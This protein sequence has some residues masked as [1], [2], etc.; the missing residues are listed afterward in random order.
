MLYLVFVTGTAAY[1]RDEITLW[2]KPEAVATGAPDDFVARGIEA[3]QARAPEAKRWGVQFPTDRSPAFHVQWQPRETGRSS[4]QLHWDERT[5]SFVPV[6]GTEGGN[7]LYRFHYSLEMEEAGEWI[8]GFATL[9]LCIAIL[10]GVVTHRRFF[11][12]FFTFRPGKSLSRSWLD[13]HN[14]TGV[15][16]LP[17]HIMISYTGLVTLMFLYVPWAQFALYG[18][19][20]TRFS[21]EAYGNAKAP[22]ALQRPAPLAD[23]AP[24]IRAVDAR[25]GEGR[26][27]RLIVYNPGDAGAEVEFR[28]NYSGQ[29]SLNHAKI[30]FSGTDGTLVRDVRGFGPGVKTRGG[31]VGMHIARFAEPV[32]RAL[33]FLCGLVGSVMIASGL[34]LWIEKRRQK[35]ARADAGFRFVER[36]N[37]GTVMGAPIAI[38][39]YFAA[40]RLLPVGLAS[41]ADWEVRAFILALLLVLVF[42]FLRAPAKAWRDAMGLASLACIAVPVLNAITTDRGIANS[43][44]RADWLFVSFDAIMLAIGGACAMACRY[45]HRR[46]QRPPASKPAARLR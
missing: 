36:L 32:L 1:Y 9:A 6:R 11:K 12:D 26:I 5:Q 43:V 20:G 23:I 2:M 13:L 33:F 19:D 37:I 18:A 35:G 4:E 30:V 17:F 42:A 25:W 24:M 29:V 10:S 44:A 15:L 3:L 45:L 39:V 8:V 41:R 21:Q 27:E 16:A 46:S 40:N 28:P 38:A 31:L 22:V 34:I 14:V 7:F